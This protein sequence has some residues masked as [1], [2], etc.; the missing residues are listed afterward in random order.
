MCVSAVQWWI[1]IDTISLQ[2]KLD[3]DDVIKW[4]YFPRYWLFVRGIHRSLL[5]HPPPPPPPTH[6]HTQWPMTRSFVVFLD[7][8]LN[9]WLTKQSRCRWFETPS[10]SLWCHCNV[11]S[12]FATLSDVTHITR[13]KINDI[14]CCWQHV[15]TEWSQALQSAVTLLSLG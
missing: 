1:I 10:R 7:L 5:D 14:L 4:K 6:T 13:E 9:K 15:K 8:H 2:R 3:H 12:D 11:S